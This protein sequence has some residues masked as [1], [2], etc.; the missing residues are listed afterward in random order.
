MAETNL[1]SSATNGDRESPA[2][3]VASI[4]GTDADTSGKGSTSMNMQSAISALDSTEIDS[5]IHDNGCR[6]KGLL[7]AERQRLRTLAMI[8]AR[9]SFYES[10][11][12]SS[13]EAHEYDWAEDAVGRTLAT[14]LEGILAKAW[15]AWASNTDGGSEE[16][17]QFGD[18]VRRRDLASL[19]PME[20]D[21]D[22]N[23]HTM[24]T[25]VRSLVQMLERSEAVEMRSLGAARIATEI[26]EL[27]KRAA[28]AEEL[29]RRAEYVFK[30]IGEGGLL[31]AAPADPDDY[32][33]HD[34]GTGLLFMLEDEITRHNRA[35]EGEADTSVRL[36]WLTKQLKSVA[37]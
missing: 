36:S 37:A 32:R 2:T 5:A 23:D 31:D 35:A 7:G 20:E 34:V 16:N 8:E 19:E 33:R 15:V 18:I 11:S 12:H 13:L 29:I 10:N 17:R 14:T 30:A 28:E 26:E 1:T 6:D 9:G 24:L 25:L 27:S 4:V 3:G 22:W 21:L